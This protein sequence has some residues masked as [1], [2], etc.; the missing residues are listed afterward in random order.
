MTAKKYFA[1]S[2][3]LFAMIAMLFAIVIS[4]QGESVFADDT[5]TITWLNE[6]GTLLYSESVAAGETPEYTGVNLAKMPTAQ[7]TYEH[8]G[9]DPEIEPA[10]QD[11][12]YTAV[13]T[14][15]LRTYTITWQLENGN[16]LETDNNVPYGDTPECNALLPQME[17]DAQYTYGTP[18]W[19]PAIGTVTGDQIY[20]YTFPKTVNTYTITWVDEDGTTILE[21][22]EDVEYGE[23]PTYNGETPTKASTAQYT[24]AFNGWTPEVS[25]VTGAQTYKAVY[26]ETIRTYK[27]TWKLDN[28]NVLETDNN[29][30]YGA[31]PTYDGETP[32]KESTA[33]YSYTFTGWDPEVSAITGDTDYT[34]Q[35]S[36]TLRTYKITWKLD[37]GN[38]L[39]TDNNVPYGATPEFNGALPTKMNDAQYTYGTPY[40]SPEVTTVTG[41]Q[42]Y[43]IVI[44]ATVNTYTI[45]W[46]DED[47]T[48]ILE[49]D[50]GVEYG[51]TPTYD[52]ETPTKESTAQY[53]YAFNCWSPAISEV[54]GNITY[55]AT[56]EATTR[57]YF[58]HWL[59]G[60]IIL[61][62][63][64]GVEYGA[65]PTYDGETP[66]KE[67]TAQYSYTFTGWDPEVSAITGDTDYTAQFSETIR[68]Y[69]ITWNNYDDS[70]LKTDEDIRYGEMPVYS[71][72]TPT[73]PSDE[74]YDYTFSGWSPE[75]SAVTG[76]VTYTAQ[77]SNTYIQY[78]IEYPSEPGYV[79]S[80]T[81]NGDSISSGSTVTYDDTVVVSYAINAG[82]DD[83]NDFEIV[84]VDDTAYTRVDNT[85]TNIHTDISISVSATAK[86]YVITFNQVGINP[87]PQ[88]TYQIVYA[89]KVTLPTAT[90]DGH[91]FVCWLHNDEPYTDATGAMLEAYNFTGGITLE[92]RFSAN[93]YIITY[94]EY[95]KEK[96]DEVTYGTTI[97]LK[98]PTRPGYVFDGW[99][100]GLDQLTTETCE[101]INA[102]TYAQDIEIESHWIEIE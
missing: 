90:K 28:G 80:V 47:G 26:S 97:T 15:T 33:Q 1:I 39:E 43:T 35:F 86:N 9:W 102:Y 94:D 2:L 49:T 20:V 95:T 40:W 5:Y 71:G 45:T 10:T 38:V 67:S 62:T 37:N 65:T 16:V 82:Y 4:L 69:K 91:T 68:S 11:Q 76:N 41:D 54:Q 77:F 36:E 50:E 92:A 18:Y 27:I 21:T 3:I 81:K 51:E 32:T 30:P 57:T 74:R 56:Y 44:P 85:L 12:T 70:T 78:K 61:E 29:V 58:V 98:M 63:D 72:D 73:K 89:Q 34:A 25:S 31:T 53:S 17:D 100:Y 22:D 59:N 46:V 14:A 83:N 19:S 23:T 60:S 52:G 99:Y 42:T 8:T 24:Y 87:M 101:L 93:K 66:T 13:Y 6:N 7:Y 96:S 84:G 79:I 55:V 64:V 48:T 88:T 75:V